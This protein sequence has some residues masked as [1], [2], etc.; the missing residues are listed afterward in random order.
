MD[1]YT[2]EPAIQKKNLD[3]SPYLE[4]SFS[5]AFLS[6]FAP[7]LALPWLYPEKDPVLFFY[8][9]EAFATSFSSS[10]PR[11][12]RQEQCYFR[13]LPTP[14]LLPLPKRLHRYSP[15][16]DQHPTGNVG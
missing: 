15:L 14:T 11:A 9:S 8:P 3:C 2:L 6:R 1:L 4:R 16:P 13:A 10:D 12:T 5:S 7:A